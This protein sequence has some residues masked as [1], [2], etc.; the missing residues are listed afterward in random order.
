MRDWKRYEEAKRLRDTGLTL[1]ATGAA[2]GVSGARVRDMLATLERRERRRAWEAEN[3]RPKPWWQGLA[4]RT[5]YELERAGFDSRESCSEFAAD[6]LTIWRGAAVFKDSDDADWWR[7]TQKR[8][9]LSMVN[10]IRAWLGCQPYAKAPKATT[11]AELER[12]RKL[13]ERN[14]WRVEP[15]N[16]EAQGPAPRGP[17]R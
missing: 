12:A 14:G 15:P 10:E 3:P 9:P 11:A 17:A 8:F 16:A 13:L 7:W 6:E 1:K 2:L 5:K 4:H